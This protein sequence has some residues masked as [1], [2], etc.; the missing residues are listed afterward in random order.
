M[1]L[2]YYLRSIIEESD[3]YVLTPGS[4]SAILKIRAQIIKLIEH[5][6]IENN[7]DSLSFFDNNLR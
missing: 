4:M 7:W 1:F 2:A 5:F 3:M 6:R